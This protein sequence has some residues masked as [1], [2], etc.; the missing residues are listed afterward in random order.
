[1]KIQCLLYAKSAM[2]ESFFVPGGDRVQKRPILMVFYLVQTQGKNILIDAGCDELPGF[3]FTEQI[4]SAEAVRQA[5]LA[6][7][8]ITDIIVTHVHQDHVQGVKYFPNATIHIQEDEYQRGSRFIPEGMQVQTF[9][10]TTQ[11]ASL[12]VIKIGGHTKGSCVVRWGKFLFVGD[13][14]YSPENLQQK[15]RTG[16][17]VAPEKSQWFVEEYAQ[18]GSV[19]LLFHDPGIR[20]GL[21]YQGEDQ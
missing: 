13:E 15:I 16:S 20:L 21:V 3:E 1:M 10:D 5:G 14:Y 7:E 12:Q 8:D 11:V 18:D 17:S 4:S 6:P 9:T 19:H 2:A